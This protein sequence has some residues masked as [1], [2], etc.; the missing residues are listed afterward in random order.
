MMKWVQRNPKK[1]PQKSDTIVEKLA[2]A[3]GIVNIDDWLNP[4]SSYINDPYGLDNIDEAVEKI[5]KAIYQGKKIQIMAD[6][7]ADGVFACAG[8]FNYLRELMDSENLSYIHSQRSKGHGVD[9]VI[10]PVDDKDIDESVKYL[11]PDTDLL[12]IVDS[13]SN[14][15]EGCQYIKEILGIDIVVIDHHQVERENPYITL[16]NCQLGDYPNKSLS[17]SAMVYKVCKVIDDYIGIENADSFMDLA[18]IGLISDM[19]N[20]KVKENRY[21]I[22]Q[23]LKNVTNFGLKELLRQSKVSTD[24]DISTTTISFKVSPAISSCTRYDKIE[25]AI[26]LLTSTDL[27]DI[28]ATAK[29]MMKLNQQRKDEEATIVKSALDNVV[30]DHNVAYLIDDE[31]GSGF[32]G[33]VAMQLVQKLNKPVIVLKEYKNDDG[34]EVYGGSGRTLGQLPLKSLLEETKQFN[35]CQGH[36]G[37]FGLEIKKDNLSEAMAKMDEMLNEDDL[38]EIVYYDLELDVEDITEMDVIDVEKFSLISGQG[39]PTPKFKIK[40]LMVGSRNVLGKNKD[41]IKIECDSMACMKFKV[42]STYATDIVEALDE[43]PFGVEIEVVG[44]LNL[45]KFFNYGLRKLIVTS[46]VLIDDYRLS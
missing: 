32:R 25:L 2:N 5:T 34:E 11:S 29:K 37:A 35:W 1:K 7:D 19:M 16:V 30:N 21:L 23:G 22:Y 44:S 36:E 46:Q 14:S 38:E 17:G 24:D 6:V 9:T 39:F 41:T 12:I 43:D 15:V 4:P 8:M 40:G 31:I 13:S 45:N 18:V 28:V 42:D 27:E 10:P 3:R 20:I 26:N 33:L